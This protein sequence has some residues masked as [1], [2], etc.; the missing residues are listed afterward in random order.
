MTVARK[1]FLSEGWN[2]GAD[3]D[4]TWVA[5][6]RGRDGGKKETGAH[7]DA[8]VIII[9][10]NNYYNN[11]KKTVEAGVEQDHISSSKMIH[12]NLWDKKTQ[13]P[14]RCKVS[15]ILY[16]DD[17]T[18]IWTEWELEDFLRRSITRDQ[19]EPTLMS[20]ISMFKA[21]LKRRERFPPRLRVEDSSTREKLDNNIMQH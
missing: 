15:N 17:G 4:F 1:Y 7:K 2:L 12:R 10:N 19:P 8:G 11:N 21:T 20:F 5:R 9:M 6:A 18:W 14:R 3:T 13:R 16:I